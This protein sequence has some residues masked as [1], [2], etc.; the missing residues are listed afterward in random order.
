[1]SAIVDYN[2]VQIKQDLPKDIPATFE[3]F[4]YF[5]SHYEEFE[6]TKDVK[7]IITDD[8]VIKNVNF[9]DIPNK[10]FPKNITFTPCVITIWKLVNN[11]MSRKKALNCYH[12]S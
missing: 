3:K 8:T 10:I 6:E 2:K 4:E 5:V 9:M 7:S 1:M 12:A 11:C